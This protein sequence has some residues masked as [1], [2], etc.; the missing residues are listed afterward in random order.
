MPGEARTRIAGGTVSSNPSQLLTAIFFF[1][2]SQDLVKNRA[3]T[4]VLLLI[5]HSSISRFDREDTQLIL[6]TMAPICLYFQHKPSTC[7]VRKPKPTTWWQFSRKYSQGKL[8]AL[9][10]V[11]EQTQSDKQVVPTDIHIP[12]PLSKRQDWNE[13]P[14]QKLLLNE[15]ER[16]SNN[17]GQSHSPSAPLL[18]S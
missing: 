18:C 1:L 10:N 9:P 3:D 5:L 4:N 6:K 16:G 8:A 13:W 15:V 11:S 7:R 2:K 12:A 14:W 17:V